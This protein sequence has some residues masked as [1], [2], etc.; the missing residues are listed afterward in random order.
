MP[1]CPFTVY[2]LYNLWHYV[3][4]KLYFGTLQILLE[5]DRADVLSKKYNAIVLRWIC[6]LTFFFG[7]DDRDI[8]VLPFVVDLP[9]DSISPMFYIKLS[10]VAI[11]DDFCKNSSVLFVCVCSYPLFSDFLVRMRC[12]TVPQLFVT[13]PLCFFC[14]VCL[15]KYLTLSTC[16]KDW[17]A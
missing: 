12:C 4:K 16:W 1:H 2:W 8:F 7:W 13:T 6:L 15:S 5:K 14:A 11:K 17:T 3:M 9:F 10:Y